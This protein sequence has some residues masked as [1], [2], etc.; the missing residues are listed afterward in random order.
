MINL[1]KLI[2]KTIKEGYELE[3]A[4]AKICQDIILSLIKNSK[5]KNNV[6]IK[7]GV[8]MRSI[9]KN[10]RRATIDIDFD[11]IK[12]P[13]SKKGIKSF[14]DVLNDNREGLKIT[15]ADKIQKLHH[16]SY[17]GARVIIEIKDSY[18]YKHLCKMD[19]GVHKYF[20]LK[21]DEFCFLVDFD[22]KGITLLV[23]SKEQMLVEKLKSLLRF[24]ANT[25]RYKDIYDMY[26]LS[27]NV[28][29][30]KLINYIKI[31]IFDDKS[32][33]EKSLKEIYETLKLVLTN[34]IFLHDLKLSNKNWLLID[35]KIIIKDLLDYFDNF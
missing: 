1:D 6:T 10:A 29:K 2:K 24:G 28:N 12:Y 7:G 19:I 15:I 16:Q 4:G 13:L 35:E 17:K 21:Q 23:N 20:S 25:T 22:E 32:I 14:I 30:D 8:V 34:K 3:M 5:L 11:L 33:E 18:G 9:S 31:L 26:Y 27:K